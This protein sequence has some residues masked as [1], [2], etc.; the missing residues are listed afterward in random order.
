MKKI[1]LISTLLITAFISEAQVATKAAQ[2][3]ANAK[4]NAIRLQS[5]SN[6]SV[7]VVNTLTVAAHNVTVVGTLPLPSGGA[8]SALQTTQNTNLTNINNGVTGLYD[9]IDAGQINL[10]NKASGIIN[11]NTYVSSFTVAPAAACTD[12]VTFIAPNTNVKIRKIILSGTQTTGSKVLVSVHLSTFSNTGGTSTNVGGFA[13]NQDGSVVAT[14]ATVQVYTAN[15]T[16]GS[17]TPI[18]IRYF[19]LPVTSTTDANQST[20]ELDFTTDGALLPLPAD[21]NFKIN[22]LG[23]T[24]TG[25]V[26]CCTIIWTE[27]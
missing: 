3:T 6:K 14:T 17:G 26:I 21:A 12:L 4:L 1:L 24:L 16:L 2:D 11:A 7:N 8:T 23:Q 15:P 25:G 20:V 27:G 13:Y 10:N 9:L 18:R 5:V 22:L 19:Y